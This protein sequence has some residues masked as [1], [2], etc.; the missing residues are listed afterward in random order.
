MM[1]DQGVDE[2]EHSGEMQYPFIAKIINDLNATR[3]ENNKRRLLDIKIL[4][5]MVGSIKT[6]REEAFG[7]LLSPYLC[8][9]GVFTVVSSDFCHWGQRF[10]YTPQP[11][12]SSHPVNEIH[13]YIAALDKRGM[14]LIELQR[15]GAFADYLRECSNTI[16]GRHPIAVWMHSIQASMLTHDVRFVSYD[17]SEKARSVRDN[18]VSYASAVARVAMFDG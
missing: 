7:R 16:C 1:M 17:Q 4:P 2:E 14:D 6:D 9:R 11:S 18:S 12:S 5:I 13:E 10:N 3:S 15:P 8:D